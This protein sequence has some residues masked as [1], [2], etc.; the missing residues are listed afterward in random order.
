VRELCEG[1]LACRTPEET[2][3]FL[4][5][6]CTPA[7]LLAMADRWRVAR[8]L[9]KGMAYRKI[10]ERTGVSTATVT[11]VARALERGEGGYLLALERLEQGGDK[12]REEQGESR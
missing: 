9:A 4:L 3:R 6:L 8:L 11:R 1:L 10:Y 7:E 5:D 2:K 12:S